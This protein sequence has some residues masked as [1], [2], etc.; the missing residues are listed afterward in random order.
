MLSISTLSYSSSPL[1][2]NTHIHSQKQQQTR[3]TRKPQ[4]HPPSWVHGDPLPDTELTKIGPDAAV[5]QGEMVG[6]GVNH[7][8]QEL[9]PEQ[10]G[11]RE[12]VCVCVWEGRERWS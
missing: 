1:P 11:R 10:P 4:P 2:I 8:R 7:T 9:G 3:T 5:E 12:C 6:E